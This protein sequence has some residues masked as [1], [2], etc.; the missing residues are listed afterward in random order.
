MPEFLNLL[1]PLEAL[2][3]LLGNL[4]LNSKTEQ[5][6]TGEGLGR[7]LAIPVNAS[8]PLPNFR[9]STVDGYAVRAVDT[10]GASAS[11]PAYLSLWGEVRM[12][13][14]PDFSISK[15][16]CGLIHTG[17]M[18]P[19][20]AD[21]VVMV[22]DTQQARDGEIE[23][24]KAVATGEN[25]LQVG[26]DVKEDEEIIPAYRLIRPAEIGGMMALGI[27]QIEVMKKPIVGIIS[28]GDEVVPPGEEIALGQ[29]RDINSYTLA[30]LVEQ[31]GGVP[32][33]Y[34]IFPDKKEKIAKALKQAH[35]E[36]DLV[37][38]TAGSSASARDLTS[39]V[40][41]ELGDPGVLVHGV[42]VRP[43]KPTILGVC[44]GKPVIGLPGNPVS[45]LVIARIFVVGVIK[46]MLGIQNEV[47]DIPSKAKLLVNLSSQSGREDW[48][49]VQLMETEGGV[50]ANPVFGKSNLIFTLVKANGILRI[51]ADA[52]G[53][54]AG[55]LVD[56]WV[57]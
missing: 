56:V 22:E 50:K 25:V 28:T 43:G 19:E 53:I 31:S 39:I 55:E 3:V 38:V 15:S 12:G 40:I 37:V 13:A 36:C 8:Y 20:G 30:G 6:K 27:T 24:L 26:E 16:G 21:A 1:P 17:G 46:F 4:P 41:N 51:P 44:D 52:N 45:A 42:N 29:V 10:Y 33:I 2:N 32:K 34:G 54:A 7:V 47:F 9:R 35:S 23:I 49:A 11:L 18:L 48:V 14:A 5:I 57:L